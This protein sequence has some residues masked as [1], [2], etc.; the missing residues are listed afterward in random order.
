MPNPRFPLILAAGCVVIFLAFGIRSGFG[1]FL[2]PVSDTFGWGREVFAFAIA[3]QNLMWGVTQP[4]AGGIADRYGSG[5]V[6]AAGGALYLL[7]L[8]L[9][10]QVASPSLL[11]LSA[12]VLIGIA[13]SGTAFAVVLAAI[14]RAAPESRRSWALGI[15]TAAGSFGQFTLAP[16][17][18]GFLSAYGWETALLLLALTSVAMVP[19]ARALR[20]RAGAPALPQSPRE[21]IAEASRNRSYWFLVGGFFVC[22]FHVAF[23]ATH[24][25]AYLTDAGLSAGTGAWAIGLIGFFN[26]I[27]SYSA[28]VLGDKLPKK[29]LLSGIYLARAAVILLYISFPPSTAGTLLFAA[30]MGVLWLS[31]VPLTSGIVG[32]VFGPQYLGMLF[33]FVFFSHQVGSFLGVWLGGLLFDASGSYMAVW[34]G[35]VALGVLSALVHLPIREAP[36]ARPAEV[37]A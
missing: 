37:K 30:A 36:L 19:L 17:G 32:Q 15:G 4:I 35:S 2:Q 7:G 33:G 22:G 20:G 16:L 31:T 10:S 23:I 8:V 21:A 13:L 28:G 14:A 3:L 9:M 29:F 34:W 11:H 1:L 24:L 25:P 5:R 18:Q 12:G 6:I 26:I 27:G